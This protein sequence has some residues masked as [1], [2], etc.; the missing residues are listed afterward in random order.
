VIDG[1]IGGKLYGK[2]LQRVRNSG[3]RYMTATVTATGTKYAE[4]LHLVSSLLDPT[5]PGDS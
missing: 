5:G 2:L 1:L 3:K 4:I